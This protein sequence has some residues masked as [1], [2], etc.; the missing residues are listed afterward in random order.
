M[1]HG[2]LALA[3]AHLRHGP[4]QG[5]GLA[6]AALFPELLHHVHRA[7]HPL[8]GPTPAPRGEL[9]QH[10]VPVLPVVLIILLATAA[11]LRGL[12]RHHA[13]GAQR[14]RSFPGRQRRQIRR[15]ARQDDALLHAQGAF[16]HR[17]RQGPRLRGEPARAPGV[18]PAVAALRCGLAELQGEAIALG[19]GLEALVLLGLLL[20]LL[21]QDDP[22]GKGELLLPLR[23][24]AHAAVQQE[25]VV[26]HAPATAEAA[27]D[28]LRNALLGLCL[29]H[30]V[31]Q[32]VDDAVH[33]RD[34]GRRPC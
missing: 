23:L 16:G 19:E 14:W 20:T 10:V 7:Q 32:R 5:R 29:L 2:Q 33:V 25:G 30:A 27:Q 34:G 4:R 15:L 11:A 31:R 6:M 13:E 26:A 21:G 17:R 28:L 24:H 3:A 1:R 8:G 12:G 22:Q 18:A 9:L